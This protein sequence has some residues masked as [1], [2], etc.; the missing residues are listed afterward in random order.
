MNGDIYLMVVCLFIQNGWYPFDKVGGALTKLSSNSRTQLV[1]RNAR[2]CFPDLR[3]E[4]AGY[5]LIEMLIVL[6]ILAALAALALPA[7]RGP[8]DKSRL[9][10]ASRQVQ[11]A[12]AKAR[13]FA[14]REGVLVEFRFQVDGNRWMIQTVP[15]PYATA[16]NVFSEDGRNATPSG[17]TIEDPVAS[18]GIEQSDLEIGEG[19]LSTVSSKPRILREGELP[20]TITFVEISEDEVSDQ[21]EVPSEEFSSDS[22]GLELNTTGERVLW[23]APIRFLPNGRTED[24][25]VRLSGPRDFF[26]DLKIRGL[27][28]AISYAAPYRMTSQQDSPPGMTEEFK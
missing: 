13:F 11:S 17:L 9:R 24:A 22:D 10:G 21:L 8:L 20:T 25:T 12:L 18:S 1:Q 5:T 16:E 14:I 2:V 19:G 27:T 26:V 4:R 15:A 6:A 23:S 3:L 28:G 7:M